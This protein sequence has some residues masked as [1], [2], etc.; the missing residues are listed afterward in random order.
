MDAHT[1]PHCPQFVS[2]VARS[3]QRFL[4]LV[5]PLVQTAVQTPPAQVLP[6]PQ[7]VPQAPQFEASESRRTQALP[8]TE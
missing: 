8:Q 2:S 3:T 1:A 4:Q 6:A 5:V 7:T